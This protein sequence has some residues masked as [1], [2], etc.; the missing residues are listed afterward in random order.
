VLAVLPGS[1]SHASGPDLFHKERVTP[2]SM[3]AGDMPA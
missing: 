2:V 3:A 1:L